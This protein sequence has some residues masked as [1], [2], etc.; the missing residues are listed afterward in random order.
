M[1]NKSDTAN[2]IKRCLLG[3]Q[4]LRALTFPDGIVEEEF[5]DSIS[6]IPFLFIYRD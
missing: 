4:R 6:R 1:M 5:P 3:Y 2:P